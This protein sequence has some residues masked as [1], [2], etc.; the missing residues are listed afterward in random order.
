[1]R[2]KIESPEHQE[3]LRRLLEKREALSRRVS[4]L[5][6]RLKIATGQ[7]DLYSVK[8]WDFMKAVC[9]DDARAFDSFYYDDSTNEVVFS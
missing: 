6:A 1:M 9:P 8:S 5:E 7:R 4:M 3:T 2:K